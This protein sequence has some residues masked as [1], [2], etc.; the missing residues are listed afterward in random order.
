[1]F[2]YVYKEGLFF[3]LYR[4]LFLRNKSNILY[5]KKYSNNKYDCLPNPPNG[6]FYTLQKRAK[7]H[8]SEYYSSLL[9]SC[10]DRYF[11]DYFKKTVSYAFSDYY[12]FM[13][14][15]DKHAASRQNDKK[16]IGGGFLDQIYA[17]KK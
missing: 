14:A 13:S 3:K 10:D 12:A 17:K 9:R 16:I 5:W 11:V 8:V 4:L 7:T 6:E 2:Y 15:V 1:M